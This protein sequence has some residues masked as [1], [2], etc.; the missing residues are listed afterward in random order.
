MNFQKRQNHLSKKLDTQNQIEVV[1][2]IAWP[3]WMGADRGISHTPNT[4]QHHIAPYTRKLNSKLNPKLTQSCEKTVAA[5]AVATARQSQLFAALCT[6][7]AP[8][9]LLFLRSGIDKAS[10]LHDDEV[11]QVQVARH[12]HVNA[13]NSHCNLCCQMPKYLRFS[14]NGLP[15]SELN[16]KENLFKLFIY[17]YE[18]RRV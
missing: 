9:I 5:T 14:G 16:Q 11:P 3:K 10:L 7:Y 17:I 18:V 15:N 6:R 2:L 8:L 4:I 1:T 13:P 12:V